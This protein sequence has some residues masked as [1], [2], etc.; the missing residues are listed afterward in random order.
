MALDARQRAEFVDDRSTTTTTAGEHP[1]SVRGLRKSYGDRHAVQGLDLDIHRGEVFALLGP[2]GAGK[3]TTVEILEGVRQRT[4]GDVRVLGCDPGRDRRDWRARI[5]VVPQT[6]GAYADL[7]VREVVEHFAAFYPRPL[8]VGQVIDMVGLGKHERKQSTELSGGQ[9]RRLD[10]AV[11]IVGDP[12]LIFLDE[13]TTGLDPVARREAWD[14]VRWFSHRG[15]TTVLTTHY[16]DEAEALAQ[17]AAVIVAGRVVRCGP[18]AEF[19]GRDRTP[20]TVS[21]RLPAGY[22]PG[23]PP[24]PALPALPALPPEA[25]P[26]PVG[27]D[28]VLR[29]ATHAPTALLA[30]L[31]P[32]AH[33]AGIGELSELRVHRPTLEDVYLDLIRDHADGTD[34]GTDPGADGTGRSTD[35]GTDTSQTISRKAAD[36]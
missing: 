31:A 2:N 11:G 14:L 9:A 16:L 4:A 27:A 21:F 32:W 3:T 7:T 23:S 22:G 8:P 1:V 24:L 29:I 5:G 30:V 26:A 28:G 36:R 34:R 13:P 20:S 17:R 15:R 35:R 18:L 10:V 33:A 25:E 6:T 12:E 19:G